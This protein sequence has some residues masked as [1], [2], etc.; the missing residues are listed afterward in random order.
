MKML[1]PQ[2]QY[3]SLSLCEQSL[4]EYLLEQIL[5]SRYAF[6]MSTYIAAN[7]STYCMEPWEAMK[8]DVCT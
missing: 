5:A 2:P 8:A 7:K 4:G 3:F 6:V 1:V